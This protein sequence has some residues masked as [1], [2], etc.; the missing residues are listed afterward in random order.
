MTELTVTP[1]LILQV[2][3]AKELEAKADVTADEASPGSDFDSGYLE[4][5]YQA[6]SVLAAWLGSA[7]ENRPR[8]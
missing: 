2:L 3:R 4:G 7:L 8:V 5:R 1:E 6:Y